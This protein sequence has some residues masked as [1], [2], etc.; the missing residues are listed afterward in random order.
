MLLNDSQL[1]RFP[2][3]ESYVCLGLVLLGNLFLVYMKY[4]YYRHR[5]SI[6]HLLRLPRYNILLLN[7][8]PTSRLQ[9]VLMIF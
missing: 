4:V 8:L 6:V 5:Y 1:V 9:Q 3:F 7:M 2:S